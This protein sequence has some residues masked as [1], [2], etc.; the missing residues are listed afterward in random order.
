MRD[1]RSNILNF[2]KDYC[3]RNSIVH[4]GKRKDCSNLLTLPYIG[5]MIKCF[6]DDRSKN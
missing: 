6:V 3:H 5:R 4:R 2:F 1:T